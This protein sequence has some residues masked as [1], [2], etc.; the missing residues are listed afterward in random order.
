MIPSRLAAPRGGW[1]LLGLA[2]FAAGLGSCERREPVQTSNPS[3]A[4]AGIYKLGR[5]YQVGDTWYR[6]AED[7]RYDRVGI[8]SWYGR[9][10]HGQPTANGEIFDM[11][12][13]SAAH[14]TLPLPSLVEV[15]NLANGRRLT[16]RVNDRGPFAGDRIIDLSRRGAELLGFRQQGTARVRV[17]LLAEESRILAELAQGGGASNALRASAIEVD[18]RTPATRAPD[19]VRPQTTHGG[20]GAKRLFVQ[21]GSF[22]DRQNAARLGERLSDLAPTNIVS[23]TVGGRRYYRLRLGPAPTAQQA[24]ALLRRVVDAGVAGARI[25][26]D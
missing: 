13:V 25:I 16:V 22:I 19:V 1:L 6:P 7:Y 21:A 17:R 3:A 12:K 9:K 23:A 10:F 15:T 20:L 18:G 24:D 11:R 2:F 14:P 8:A 4:G 26:V 5:P